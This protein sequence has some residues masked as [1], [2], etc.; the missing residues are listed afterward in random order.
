[1]RAT[2]SVTGA[3]DASQAWQLGWMSNFLHDKIQEG[4]TIEASAPFG[5]FFLDDTRSPVVLISAG[6]GVTPL[7]SMLHTLLEQ[8]DPRPVSWVQ[9]VRSRTAHP[10][11][12]E[13][14]RLLGLRPDIV[15]RVVFYSSP[16]ESDLLGQ[17]YDC[18]GR[19]ELVKIP[20]DTLR[21]DDRTAH[22]YVCGPELFM[23]QI[24]HGLKA[25]GVGT[26]RI[27]AEVFGQGAVPL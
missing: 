5:D 25:R 10:L 11:H 20:A 22:Y 16:A 1:M 8:P 18:A 2:D 26:H 6:V 27:H 3:V 14:Q 13:V 12:D 23:A 15:K 9:V 19:L 17:D 7:A 24:I 21:L 4:D